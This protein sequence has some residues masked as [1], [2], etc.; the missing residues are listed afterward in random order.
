V[1]IKDVKSIEG[2]LDKFLKLRPVSYLYR[3]DEFPGKN[4]L[5]KE[6]TVL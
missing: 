2:I 6:I 1:L 3:T 4:F 5:K